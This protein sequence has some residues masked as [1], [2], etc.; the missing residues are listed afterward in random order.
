MTA[1]HYMSEI[2]PEP[3]KFDIDRFLPSRRK[4]DSLGFAP[5]GLGTH[6]CLGTRWMEMH[7]AVNLLMLAHYFTIEVSPA[8]YVRKLRFNPFPSIKP[9]KKLKFRIAEQRREL[10]A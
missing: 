2:F 4:H 9:S 5:Y 3:H 8:K 10:P 1:T 6:K 7:L